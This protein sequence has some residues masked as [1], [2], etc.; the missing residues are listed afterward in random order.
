MCAQDTALRDVSKLLRS[1]R[2]DRPG[3]K[4]SARRNV[5]VPTPPANHH[6]ASHISIRA[7]Q[8]ADIG[9]SEH[10]AGRGALSSSRCC[11]R[12]SPAAPRQAHRCPA[13]LATVTPAGPHPP[14]PFT[15]AND[16]PED[17]TYVR[18]RRLMTCY[19]LPNPI[20]ACGEQ[21]P[22]RSVLVSQPG[23][24]TAPAP[25]LPLNCGDD[26]RLGAR[27]CASEVQWS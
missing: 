19:R 23:S 1:G 18:A 14:C 16:V 27:Y 7:S 9:R 26:H 11:P 5:S 15:D 13:A 17:R 8:L 22:S 21:P 10:R 2:E 20:E 6:A 25:R 3:W 12:R 4:P 24:L